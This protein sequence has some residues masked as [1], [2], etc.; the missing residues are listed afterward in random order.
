MTPEQIRW[1]TWGAVQHRP[2]GSPKWDDAGTAKAITDHCGTWGLEV[3]TDHVLAHAR[4]PKARTPF[5][6]KGNKPHNEPSGGPRFPAG[7]GDECRYH[8]GEY[9]DACRACAADKLAGDTP[10]APAAPTPPDVVAE[11]VAKLRALRSQPESE[12]A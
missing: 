12:D 10:I 9:A 11:Q 5:V 3:A 4:D 7:K 6:I 2:H 8:K 1:L